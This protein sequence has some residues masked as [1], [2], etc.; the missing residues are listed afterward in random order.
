M[1]VDDGTDNP[2]LLRLIG[3]R[4]TFGEHVVL[5]DI[6]L[7]VT[8][9]EVI[10]VIGASGSGKSTLLRCINL[11]E[12]PSGGEIVFHNP[13]GEGFDFLPEAVAMFG[14]CS[15]CRYKKRAYKPFFL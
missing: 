12:A 10:A 5:K 7:E 11:L 8:A 14:A 4:K 1:R 3:L 2:V 15:M 6:S 13:A 9:G